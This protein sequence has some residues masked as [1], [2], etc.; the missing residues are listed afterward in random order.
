MPRGIGIVGI[1]AY[2]PPG[3]IQHAYYRGPPGAF[4]PF[5]RLQSA[6][7]ICADVS[8]PSK[9]YRP[10]YRYTVF[11]AIDDTPLHLIF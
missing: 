7:S 9:E 6:A 8:V 1:Q 10:T 3:Y 5:E 2:T 4:R 11:G